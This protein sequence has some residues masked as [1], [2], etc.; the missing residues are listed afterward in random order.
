[1]K[2]NYKIMTPAT[3]RSKF[4]GKIKLSIKYQ[5]SS[6]GSQNDENLLCN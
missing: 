4:D 2:M 3:N 1:M 6:D 5:N